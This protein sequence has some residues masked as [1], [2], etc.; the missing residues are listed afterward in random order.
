MIFKWKKDSI[1]NKVDLINLDITEK[2]LT[3][4]LNQID[5]ILHLSGQS[6]GEISF[7]NPTEDLSKNTISTLNLINYAI[8]NRVKNNLRK[9]NVSLWKL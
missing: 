8:K 6:S 4:Y 5:F 9:F 2:N 7:E 3:N 1:P